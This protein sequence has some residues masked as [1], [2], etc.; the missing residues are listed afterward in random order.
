MPTSPPTYELL[1]EDELRRDDEHANA[2]E[3]DDRSQDLH[4]PIF[5][6]PPKG[7]FNRASPGRLRAI[8]VRLADGTEL[9]RPP[10]ISP[11][12]APAAELRSPPLSPSSLQSPQPIAAAASSSSSLHAAEE[13][14]GGLYDEIEYAFELVHSRE[15][16]PRLAKKF[17][18]ECVGG[19]QSASLADRLS[20][21]SAVAAEAQRA[22]LANDHFDGTH[23][24]AAPAANEN[25]EHSPPSDFAPP[26]PPL[27]STTL[28]TMTLGRSSGV[29]AKAITS[30]WA[31]SIAF[32]VVRFFTRALNFKDLK[33][34][35]QQNIA[36]RVR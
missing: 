11:P 27:S 7:A 17:S 6:L 4:S 15:P 33:S 23:I 1:S 24:D 2:D 18:I 22:Q 29:A 34:D 21:G 31:V 13:T 9:P 19:S 35:L 3:N 36:K 12:P 32:Y 25:V 16:T 10:T 8:R 28:T 14:N 26:L 30:R 20:R 5:E